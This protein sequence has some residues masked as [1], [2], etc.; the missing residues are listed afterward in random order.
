VTRERRGH[1]CFEFDAE[2]KLTV[3][4]WRGLSPVNVIMLVDDDDV[5]TRLE[6]SVHCLVVRGFCLQVLSG[7]YGQQIRKQLPS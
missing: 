3:Q 4:C 5:L 1:A 2:L 6:W 7:F